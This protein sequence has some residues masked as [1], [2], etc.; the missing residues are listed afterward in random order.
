MNLTGADFDG[1]ARDDVVTV[2][3]SGLRYFGGADGGFTLRNRAAAG[4]PVLAGLATAHAADVDGDGDLDLLVGGAGGV[5]WL[6]SNVTTTRRATYSFAR[7]QAVRGRNAEPPF[8]AVGVVAIQDRAVNPVTSRALV[9]PPVGPLVLSYAS[10][11]SASVTLRWIDKVAVAGNDTI[12][13][14][15]LPP[16][17]AGAAPLRQNAPE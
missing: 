3:L 1:D 16:Q 8:D 10:A 7:L 14:P 2:G 17:V 12:I 4:L 13:I 9:H 15:V 5:T 6:R 11:P